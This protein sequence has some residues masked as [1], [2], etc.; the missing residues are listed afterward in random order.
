MKAFIAGIGILCL[1][2]GAIWIFQGNDFF[3]YKIFAPKYESVRRDV[4]EESK[5]YNEGMVQELEN[6]HLEWIKA[7][8]EGKDAMASIILHRASAY[9]QD[10]LPVDLKIFIAQLKNEQGKIR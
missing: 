5:A 3:M 1:F 7:T 2:L 4:F 6:M 9:D 8:P 10:K